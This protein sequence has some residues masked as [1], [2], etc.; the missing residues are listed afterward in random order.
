MTAPILVLNA[1]SSSVKFSLRVGEDE[2]LHGLVERLGGTG[3]RGHVTARDAAGTVV[4]DA[5][6]AGA[7]H[8]DALDW[9][10]GWL[11]GH[12]AVA[13]AA[14][15]HR[16]VHGGDRYTAPVR[17]TLDVLRHLEELVPL[18]PLHQPHNLGPVAYFLEKRPDLPQVA[19]FDTAFH[20]TQ[21]RL[22]RTFALPRRYFD[23]GVKRY[24]FHGLSY[25]YVTGRLA[26][27]DPRAA[28]GKTIV[29]HLGNG[30]SLCALSGGRS[31]ASTMGFTALDGLVMGTRTGAIDPGVLLYLLQHDQLTP[32]QLSDLLYKQSGLLGISGV[33]ADMRDLLASDRPEAA[34]AVE[35]F[36][37]R[38]AREIG[39]LAAVL[40]GL[41]A[42]VF[43]A[44][45]GEHAAAVR[46]RVC[47]RCA[48]L[49]V[50]LD[51][52]A[53]TARGEV[54][55]TPA[56]RVA[57]RIVP[58]DEERMIARHAARALAGGTP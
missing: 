5:D 19:C 47:E 32:D 23:Q 12:A 4:A 35:L 46:A 29:C 8:A 21:D 45:I 3:G 31:V 52:A 9:L 30:A 49:G 55:S 6:L 44:G 15:G 25:E 7:T 37:Y 2:R 58:T 50:A 27:I 42:L 1:G 39:A 34:E 11:P 22:E 54:I 18:A 57:V 56:S 48:W 28:Q 20:A 43:T 17:V 36:C 13:P 26:E 51:P 16:V 24:G 38:I 14:V 33:S 10:V 41:D 53:N 40:G